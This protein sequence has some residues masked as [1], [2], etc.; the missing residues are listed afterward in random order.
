MDLDHILS[1]GFRDGIVGL[2]RKNDDRWS[3]KG[4]AVDHARNGN[5]IE[6]WV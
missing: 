6:H 4:A 2:I 1:P 5:S 3:V